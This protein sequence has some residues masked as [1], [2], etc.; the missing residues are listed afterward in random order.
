MVYSIEKSTAV[1]QAFGSRDVAL[2][3]LLD[4]VSCSV[5]LPSQGLSINPCSLMTSP[6]YDGVGVGGSH[7][8]S[9]GQRREDGCPQ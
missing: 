9:G 4:D 8:P 7:H 3:P 1:T 6:F 5:K 2:I